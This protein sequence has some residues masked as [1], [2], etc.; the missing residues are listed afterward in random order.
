MALFQYNAIDSSGKPLSGTIDASG[1]SDAI[2]KL[3]SMGYFVTSVTPAKGTPTKTTEKGKTTQTKTT[4]KSSAKGLSISISLP[5]LGNKIKPKEL[6]I[7]TRQLA[8]LIGAGLPLLRSLRVLK[9]QRRGA[10]SNILGKIAD[11]IEQGALFSEALSKHPS[12]F[13]RIYVAMVKAGEAGGAL[14]IVLSRLADFMEKEAKL[15]GKIKSA[16]AYPTVVLIVTI[17]M[18]TFIM[19]KI[20]PTFIQIFQDME[21]GDLPAPTK[22]VIAISKLLAQKSPFVVMGIFALFIFYRILLKIKFTRYWIDM[23]KLRIFLFGPI[24]SKTIIARFARTFATLISSGVPILQ[25]LQIVRDTVGNEV[26]ANGINEIRNRVRE[27]EGIAGPMLRTKVF[28]PMVTNMVAVGEETGQMDAMLDKIADAYEAEVDSAVAALASMIEPIMIV[29]LGG[30]VGFIVIS[31][32]M[33]LI[34]IAMSL[35]GATGGGGE[36]GGE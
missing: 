35:S 30:V 11:D 20:V 34:K 3:K 8:T 10:A 23:L 1:V 13:P 15:R 18:L 9:E 14:E 28:P 24:I 19:L 16:M 36:G 4:K 6:M 26:I 29:F 27:G 22:L 17:G 5:F 32:Y 2:A 12:S 25:S 7:I 33:P 31:L 21:V